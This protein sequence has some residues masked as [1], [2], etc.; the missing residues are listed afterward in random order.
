MNFDEL[1]V[2]KFII[3]KEVLYIAIAAK[4]SLFVRPLKF[5]SENEESV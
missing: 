2:V 1:M 5:P 3:Q 4:Y